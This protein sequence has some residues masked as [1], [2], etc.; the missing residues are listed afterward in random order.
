[1]QQYFF[2][3]GLQR[4]GSTLLGSLLNQNPDFYVTPTSPFLDFLYDMDVSLNKAAEFYTFEIE[5]VKVNVSI[6]AFQSFY[7]HIDKK[8][9]LDKHR[10][11]PK[12]LGTVKNIITKN[13]KVLVTYRPIAEIACSFIKLADKD[14][15]NGLDRELRDLGKSINNTNRA[16]H[17]WEHWT[18]EVYDSLKFGLDNHREN[19]HIVHYDKLV[20]NPLDT[21]DNIY[22]FLDVPRYENHMLTNLDNS[23]SEQKDEVWG[24]KG[25]HDIRTDGIS[26]Q[27]YDPR[28]ILPPHIIDFFEAMDSQLKI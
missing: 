11:W 10:G 13:P 17:I 7:Q 20:E 21:L 6:K 27:S 14:S 3:S 2:L 4:A 12:N 18:S 19:I 5:T 16:L 22:R 24:F 15:A 23:L 8:Y 25:L 26:K 1:M 9:I 28:D